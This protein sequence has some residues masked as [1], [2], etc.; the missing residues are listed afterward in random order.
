MLIHA[1]RPEPGLS[2]SRGPLLLAHYPSIYY[3]GNIRSIGRL[4]IGYIADL[5][6]VVYSILALLVVTYHFGS[7]FADV[8]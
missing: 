7:V 8:V 1:T 6:L 4:Q 5:L 2:T 3:L